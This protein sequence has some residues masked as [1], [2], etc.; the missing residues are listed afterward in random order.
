MDIFINIATPLLRVFAVWCASV[1]ALAF[2]AGITL[3]AHIKTLDLHLIFGTIFL[4]PGFLAAWAGKAQRDDVNPSE[5]SKPFDDLWTILFVG[6]LG[7]KGIMAFIVA[8]I[9][10]LVGGFSN[11]WSG[12]SALIY[13]ANPISAL[14]LGFAYIIVF[15]FLYRQIMQFARPENDE[16]D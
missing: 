11:F 6:L 15:S 12:K 1:F 9:Y 2:A 10:Y 16:N 5:D 13:A 14:I 3:G 4:I 8:V 7:V